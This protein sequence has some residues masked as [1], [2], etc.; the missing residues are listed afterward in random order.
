MILIIEDCC[1]IAETDL[2]V[3]QNLSLYLYYKRCKDLDQN[4]IKIM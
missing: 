1:I 3:I 2:N 4:S